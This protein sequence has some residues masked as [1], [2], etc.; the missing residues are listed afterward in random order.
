MLT[1]YHY[2]TKASSIDSRE[3]LQRRYL[4][5]GGFVSKTPRW[6]STQ[7]Q[8]ELHSIK[9]C[10]SHVSTSR[11]PV[12]SLTYKN[13]YQAFLSLINFLGL[14]VEGKSWGRVSGLPTPTE[15][16]SHGFLPPCPHAHAQTL[17]VLGPVTCKNIFDASYS[18]VDTIQGWVFITSQ[19]ILFTL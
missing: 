2:N 15:Q 10:L 8:G 6:S 4:C 9:S 19:V 12:T 11:P 5:W 18:F 13:L 7:L 14:G 17:D 3:R 1:S 16:S